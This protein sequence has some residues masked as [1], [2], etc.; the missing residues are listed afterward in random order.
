VE[1]PEA[2]VQAVSELLKTEMAGVAAAP[3]LT[4]ARPLTVPLKVE[5]GAGLNWAAAH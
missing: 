4:G 3:P 2:E 5:V 1:A